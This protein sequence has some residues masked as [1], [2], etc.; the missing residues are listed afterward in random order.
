[1]LTVSDLKLLESKEIP[2]K[3]I[4]EQLRCFA[5]GFP[6]PEIKASA[7]VEKGIRIISKDE[8]LDFIKAW[9]EYLTKNKKIVKFVPASG[10]AS[11][12]FKDLYAFVAA[13]YEEPSTAFEKK[14]F[15]KIERFAFYRALNTACIDQE[16]KPL[17][18]LLAKGQ[19]KTIV[20]LLLESQGLNYG[21]LPKGLLLFHTYPQ[22]VRTAVEEH[23]AEGAMYAKNN[24]GEV[25]LHF[26]VSPEHEPFFQACIA[27]KQELYED[28]FSVKYSISFS[29]QKSA[30][31]TLAADKDNQPFRDAA[32]KLVFRP[33]GHGALIEN[34]ND[35]EADVVFVKNIDNVTP[36]S[37]KYSTV[38]YKKILAGLLVS[39]QTKIFDYL[40]LIDSGKYSH[41]QV[42]E[43]IHFLQ[44]VLCVRKLDIKHLE[45]AELMLYI[46]GKLQRPLRVC[47][48]V[49]NEGEPGGGPFLAVS[50]DG[51][52]APQILESS[53]IDLSN[54]EQKALFDQGTHFNPVDLVCAIKDHLGMK[55]H[56]PDYVD[57][58]TGFI[59]MKSKDGRELKAL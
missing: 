40:R 34:L 8:Q 26:T 50:P 14:F 39:L 56:L 31:D 57:K 6:F 41:K 54:P 22:C 25:N 46:R 7:S 3:Q 17:S 35:I 53:Q 16:G 27:Q 32:G 20:S 9:D 45:D 21:Q 24:A 47:G 49:K 59:S 36:D 52:V 23:L 13:G 1:M 10:A 48:M 38:I 44:D 11:R 29:R 5:Q 30:T 43:I 18:Q 58:N 42:E 12:M 19:Y 33:G 2:E 4:E 37:L 51:T 55:Y 15:D 28:K